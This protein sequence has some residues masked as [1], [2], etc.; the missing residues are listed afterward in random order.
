MGVVPYRGAPGGVSASAA[1]AG[2]GRLIADLPAAEEAAYDDADEGAGEGSRA[3]RF[4]LAPPPPLS[5][6]GVGGAGMG[7]G[8]A[9]RFKASIMARPRVATLEISWIMRWKSSSEHP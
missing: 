2:R 8:A 6:C 3:S 9:K 1:A 5:R 4:P 7:L